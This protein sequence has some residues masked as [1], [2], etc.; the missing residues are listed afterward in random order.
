ML[1]LW[2]WFDFSLSVP[3]QL[4]L[5]TTCN[6]GQVTWVS[7]LQLFIYKTEMSKVY[8]HKIIVRITWSKYIKH[9]CIASFKPFITLRTGF[10]VL[11]SKIYTFLHYPFLPM[12][13]Y[14][15]FCVV[16][17]NLL[18]N[19]EFISFSESCFIKAVAT[20]LKITHLC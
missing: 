2:S 9:L 5:C 4:P 18:P 16:T 8:T 20:P 12:T 14:L 13:T 15:D 10:I 17:Y 1:L 6:F 3:I 7:V 11:F 19:R